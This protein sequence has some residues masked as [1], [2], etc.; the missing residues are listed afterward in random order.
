MDMEAVHPGIYAQSSVPELRIRRITVAYLLTVGLTFLLLAVFGLIMRLTQG[1]AIDVGAVRFYQLMT[2][3]GAGMVGIM[4]LGSLA[5]MGYFLRQHVDLNPNVFAI[6]LVLS[7]VGVAMILGAIFGGGYAGAWT[8]LFPLPAQSGGLWSKNAAALFLGGLLVIGI[9]LLLFYLEAGRAI[10]A[11]YGNFARALGWPQILGKE[12]EYGPPPTVVAGTMAIIFDT[13]GLIIGASILT[14]ELVNLYLPSFSIDALLAKNMTYYFGH[15]VINATI[16]KSVIAVYEILPRYAGRPW[17][18]N[19]VFLIAWNASLLL[20][21]INFTHHLYMDAAQPLWLHVM[22]Q[23]ASYFNGLPLLVVT[24][25]GGLMLIYRSGMRWDVASG[26]LYVAL[27][28]WVIGII[29]AIVDATIVVN[30]ELHNTQW[31]SGH[32]HAYLLLGVVPM[33]FGFMYWFSATHGTRRDKG[34]DR[35]SFWLYTLGAFAFTMVFLAA[36]SH[37]VPRR[38]AVHLPE[39]TSYSLAASL[40]AA[41][42]IVAVLNFIIRFIAQARSMLAAR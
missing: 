30:R 16:Y 24:A 14:M 31:V 18:S 2:V 35:A 34:A 11:R 23:I 25:W 39:W 10:L 13:L 29:P 20:A 40:F 17:K 33:I 1:G 6:T 32:F 15:V 3:H 42:V 4:I 26:M 22:G 8:F 28:G 36:G 9:G 27:L 21:T 12:G 41:L 37:S 7:L 38:W 5:I 19:R